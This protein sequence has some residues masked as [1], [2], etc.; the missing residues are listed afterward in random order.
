M[1]KVTEKGIRVQ[2]ILL[3]MFLFASLPAALNAQGNNEEDRGCTVADLKGSFGFTFTGTARTETGPSPRAGIQ[4]YKFDGN[5]NFSGTQTTVADGKPLRRTF[6][7][8]YTVESDCTGSAILTFM[9]GNR[10]TI[11]SDFVIVDDGRE[12]RTVVTPP[13]DALT[14]LTV[15]SV[16]RK[17]FS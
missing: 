11:L 17:Q 1:I 16:G 2:T 4:R 8:T 14:P 5:G 9:D 3:L 13:S 12:V 6:V 10:A 7:G 15:T